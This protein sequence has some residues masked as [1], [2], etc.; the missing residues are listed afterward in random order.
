MQALADSK[1]SKLGLYGFDGVGKST[2]VEQIARK[3]KLNNMFDEVVIAS[4]T[5]SKDLKRI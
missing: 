4:V 2:L 3:A 1:I 5:R